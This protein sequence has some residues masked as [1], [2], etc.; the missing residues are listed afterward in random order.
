[1]SFA[2]KIDYITPEI[3]RITLRRP[4]KAN[5]ISPDDLLILEE[6]LTT[7]TAKVLILCGEGKHFC[8]GFDLS[9]L[10]AGEKNRFDVFANQLA[11][12]PLLTIALI[13]GA[14]IGGATDLAL[15]CDIV[16]GS[17]KATM[18]MP[19]AKLG[20]TLY[21]GALQRYASRLGISTAKRLIFLGERL[22][23]IEMKRIGFLT[24]LVPHENLEARA[25]EIAHHLASLPQKSALA[26]KNKLIAFM[27]Q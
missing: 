4:E 26:M 16:I 7:I 21:D 22:D 6:F 5:A 18:M 8:A 3:A 9:A 13:Q 10:K 23:A 2:P 1:M 25:L 12:A 11:N 27:T 19:A 24:E 14:V 15:G 17:E 20:V